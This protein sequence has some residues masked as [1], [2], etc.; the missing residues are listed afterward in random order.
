AGTEH[1]I[2]NGSKI[3]QFGVA[4]Q[5][6][7]DLRARSP[8]MVVL[9]LELVL[10]H[11]ELLDDR[12][13]IRVETL[14]RRGFARHVAHSP[15]DRLVPLLRESQDL[16][17]GQTGLWPRRTGSGHLRE[18]TLR[19]VIDDDH[20]LLERR[21]IVRRVQALRSSPFQHHRTPSCMSSLA[22]LRGGAPCG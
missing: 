6:L 18:S 2:T 22:N 21:P 7:L 5:S 19:P 1:E 4:F 10:V 16:H 11:L 15:N 3:E 8:K 13:W 20:G 9:D 14:S 17:F 12:S